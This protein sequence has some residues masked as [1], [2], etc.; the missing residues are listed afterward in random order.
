[1]GNID[2]VIKCLIYGMFEETFIEK[3]WAEIDT[4]NVLIEH[5]FLISP[6]VGAK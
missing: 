2:Q 5:S 4:K 3:N 6:D 1:M